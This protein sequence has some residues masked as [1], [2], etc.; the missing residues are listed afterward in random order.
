MLKSKIDV[1]KK[2]NSSYLFSASTWILIWNL[3]WMFWIGSSVSE[4]S[5]LVSSR[6]S[7]AWMGKT[8]IFH[9]LECA[10]LFTSSLAVKNIRRRFIDIWNSLLH[11]LKVAFIQKGLMNWSF[12]Q[13]DKPNF[14]SWAKICIFFFILKGSN[15]VK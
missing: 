15:H 11:S 8:L 10:F 7:F 9:S 12:L 2:L 13:A 1:K 6:N 3:W 4:D 14:F 5:W